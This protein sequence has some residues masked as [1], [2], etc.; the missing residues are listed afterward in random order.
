MKPD[1][2]LQP[3]PQLKNDSFFALLK[4]GFKR[5]FIGAKLAV[6]PRSTLQN[7]M[8]S[9]S[10]VSQHWLT[11]GLVVMLAFIAGGLAYPVPL[12][13]NYFVDKV[14]LT[15]DSTYFLEVTLLLVGLCTGQAM[16][17][18]VM[19]YCSH[20]F[21]QRTLFDLRNYLTR[22]VLGLPKNFFD[23][24]GDGYIISRMNSDI[25]YASWFF[26]NNAAH[27]I[28]N[29]VRMIG[30]VLFL[31]YIDY[32]A[33]IIAIIFSLIFIIIVVKFSQYQYKLSLNS[34]EEHALLNESSVETIANISLLKVAT[35]EYRSVAKNAG[36]IHNIYQFNLESLALR[37]FAKIVGDGMPYLAHVT[38]L[39][40]GSWWWL[41]GDKTWTLGTLI[42]VQIYLWYVFAPMK[43]LYNECLAIQKARV[44]LS[45]IAML[46]SISSEHNLTHGQSIGKLRGNIIFDS[47]AFQYNSSRLLLK[48]VSFDIAPGEKVAIVGLSGTGKT[49]LAALLMGLYRPIRGQIYFD[50]IPAEE[51]NLRKLRRR[52]GY[53]PQEPRLFSGTLLDT[54]RYF[55]P[56]A[57]EEKIDIAL[58]Q[59]GLRQF[60]ALLQ[61][62]VKSKL[63]KINT[64]LSPSIRQRLMLAGYLLSHPDILVLDSI[65]DSL[66]AYNENRLLKNIRTT[67]N[68]KTVVMISSRYSTVM[69]A[70]KVILLHQGKIAGIG[71]PYGLEKTSSLFCKLLNVN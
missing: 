67:F 28:M 61:D 3:I 49:T 41:Q 14:L 56:N 42:A 70:D 64:E 33:G 35:Q 63:G 66:D 52:I 19:N 54:I 34:E 40:L 62:G 7:L 44:A 50:G 55:A 10:I 36:F 45:R 37:S 6:A 59:V 39:I 11:G 46:F 53:I 26:S 31:F 38:M 51:C 22:R 47:V 15:Q 9:L 68:H 16:T 58:E 29:F 32:R 25:I 21:E 13:I 27:L 24:F 18:M 17:T 69:Q 71:T 60:I 48:Q 30:G 4:S 57:K 2:K 20:L 65:T 12:I 1:F 43:F 23:R 5:Q 8:K